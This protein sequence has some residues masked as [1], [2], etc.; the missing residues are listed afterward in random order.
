MQPL[1]SRI[2][3]LLHMYTFVRYPIT[4]SHF[5]LPSS[6]LHTR[7]PYASALHF[8]ARL[9]HSTISHH[10]SFHPCCLKTGK[11]ES[12]VPALFYASI[13][14]L[15]CIVATPPTGRCRSP[16]YSR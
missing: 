7:P 4:L 2:L 6:S 1:P 16:A 12:S 8:S 14:H 3:V 15:V 11:V 5:F 13:L 9:L 10:V